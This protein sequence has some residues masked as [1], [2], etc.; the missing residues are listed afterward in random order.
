MPVLNI[1]PSQHYSPKTPTVAWNLAIGLGQSK[2]QEKIS[3]NLLVF[4]L[5]LLCQRPH[6]PLLKKAKLTLAEYVVE[7]QLT[8]L[9]H[10]LGTGEAGQHSRARMGRLHWKRAVAPSGWGE[11]A[12]RLSE[13]MQGRS[14][15]ELLIRSCFVHK[16]HTCLQVQMNHDLYS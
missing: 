13:F 11:G 7:T 4:Y 2:I 1:H 8:V 9:R 5:F 16:N 6:R 14:K 10:A 15:E 3:E 12:Q